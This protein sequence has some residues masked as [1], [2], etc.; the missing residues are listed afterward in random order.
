VTGGCLGETAAALVDGELDHADRERAQRH[1]AHCSRCRSEVEAQRRLKAQVRAAADATPA[2]PPDL[3][4]RLLALPGPGAVA[5][6]ATP[7]PVGPRVGPV[8]VTSVRTPARARPAARRRRHRRTAVV[9]AAVLALAG[10][11]ALGEPPRTASTPVDPGSPVFVV[12]HV[13]T[14]GGAV[15]TVPVIRAGGGGTGPR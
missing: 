4:A 10:V 1:L 15:R 8:P 2:P 13:G 6:P 12:E 9:S 11:L 14:T 5:G 7:V 3:A